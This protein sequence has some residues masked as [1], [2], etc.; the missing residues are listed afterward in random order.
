MVLIKIVTTAIRLASRYG[1]KTVGADYKVFRKVGYNRRQS[2]IL[3]GSL[4]AGGG[5][6]YLTTDF[7]GDVDAPSLQNGSQA[8]KPNQTRSRFKRYAGSSRKRKFCNCSRYRHSNSRRYYK[9]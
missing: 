3:S 7:S 6:K 4:A 5:A 2:G 8:Y 9:R 1:S